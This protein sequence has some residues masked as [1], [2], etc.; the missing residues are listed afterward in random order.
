[1]SDFDASDWSCGP[2][3]DIS[4]VTSAFIYPATDI[5]RWW[6]PFKRRKWRR[7]CAHV[8]FTLH[9]EGMPLTFTERG[10]VEF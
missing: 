2:T 9:D 7:S 8:T 4:S 5:P 10:T 3:A 6:H 1:M